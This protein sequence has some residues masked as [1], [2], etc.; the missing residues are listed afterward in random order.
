MATKKATTT[1]STA[2]TFEIGKTKSRKCAGV[3]GESKPIN[4]FPTVSGQPGR[5]GVECRDCRDKRR[6]QATS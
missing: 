2:K 6:A 1:T 5:R 4:K 3:C